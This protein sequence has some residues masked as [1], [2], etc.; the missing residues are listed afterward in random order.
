MDLDG[1]APAHCDYFPNCYRVSSSLLTGVITHF[2]AHIDAASD[3]FW[4]AALHLRDC[5][6][7]TEVRDPHLCE[8]CA[9]K[10]LP[11]RMHLIR[12]EIHSATDMNDPYPFF[13]STL[14]LS[15]DCGN[16]SFFLRNSR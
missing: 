16:L 1:L 11:F 15:C 13:N 4:D 5:A 8:H 7:S 3:A 12:L 2:R 10:G 14:N 9:S 6:L